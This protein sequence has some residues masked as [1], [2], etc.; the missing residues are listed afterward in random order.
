MPPR[1]GAG[2]RRT[3]RTPSRAPPRRGASWSAFNPP[4][5]AKESELPL[6]HALCLSGLVA[7]ST[8]G[9]HPAAAAPLDED[10]GQRFSARD[11][12]VRRQI[13]AEKERLAGA[14]HYEMLGVP[15]DATPE[16]TKAAYLAAA[17]RY[18]SDRFSGLSL[19]N[20]RRAGE[21]LFARVSEAN[22]VLG[23]SEKRADYDIYLDRKAKGLPTD[24]AAILKAEATFQ[25][26][27]AFFKAGNWSDAEAAFREALMLNHA[28]A[29]FHAYLGMAIARGRQELEKSLECVAHALELDPR[30]KAAQLFRGILKHEV[31]ETDEAKKILRK[32]LEQ[33]PDFAEAKT[34]VSRI[35]SGQKPG[36][37]KKSA[38][39]LGRLL[40]K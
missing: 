7:M 23:S 16:A 18:H 1:L 6:L 25:K 26:G 4:R 31:G 30:S 15:P 12:E 36:D 20:A 29:E 8:P 40:K 11:E 3:R 32:L 39:V 35:R 17:K 21:E 33:D 5:R 2:S 34:E 38:G 28:A 10:K 22:E 37:A 9:G 19:G 13:F 14:T 27:E 24:V